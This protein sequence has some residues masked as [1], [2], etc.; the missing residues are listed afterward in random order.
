MMPWLLVFAESNSSEQLS[1]MRPAQVPA[2]VKTSTLLS[3]ASP[4]SIP[5]PSSVRST[6]APNQGKSSSGQFTGSNHGDN[7]VSRNSLMQLV[8][9]SSTVNSSPNHSPNNSIS[10]GNSGSN[11]QQ[12]P[13]FAG[14]SAA[15]Q[16]GTVNSSQMHPP[17]S[18]SMVAASVVPTGPTSTVEP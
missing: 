3:A 6:G 1:S 17:S 4:T 18:L 2:S 5:Q 7:M 12:P 14:T 8:A 13:L 9:T 15:V 10:N 11:V 16:Q